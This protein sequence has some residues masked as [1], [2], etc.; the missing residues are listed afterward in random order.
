MR[1]SSRTF[2]SRAPNGSSNKSSGSTASALARA[3][4]LT[5]PARELVGE[6]LLE[7][8]KVDQVDQLFTRS[9][10]VPPPSPLIFRP[11]AML[12]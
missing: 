6:T 2:A 10:I 11:K 3:I 4:R 7:A 12:S 5:L 8:P 9:R 1:S